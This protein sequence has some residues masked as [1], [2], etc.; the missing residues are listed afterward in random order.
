M[1]RNIRT[2]IGSAVT[3]IALTLALGGITGSTFR[4]TPLTVLSQGREPQTRRLLNDGFAPVVQKAAPAVVNISSSKMVK[5]YAVP[6]LADDVLERF[7][8]PDLEEQLGAPQERRERSLGSGVIVN[9]AGYVLTNNHVVENATE[10]TVSLSDDREFKGRVVGADPGTDIAVLKIN[11]EG[12][13]T[14]PFADS[15]KV[16][17]GDLALAIGNPFGLGRSVTM[18]VVSA[19]GRGGLGIE[20]YEDFIQT[21]A[22]IN[23]GSSGG[24]LTNIRGELIGMNTAILSPDGL[25]LGIG[26]AV[27]SNMVRDVMDQLLRTGKVSRGFM[28]VLLQD[29]TPEI[30]EAMKLG[31]TKGA[32]VGDVAPDT[33]AS[34]AGI[35]PGDVIVAADGKRITDRREL[36]LWIA[37]KVPGDRLSLKI[38]RDGLMRDVAVT[39]SEKP[40]EEKVE[41]E[42]AASAPAEDTTSRLGIVVS[43]LTPQIRQTLSIPATVKG[44][45]VAELEEGGAAAEAGMLPGDVIQ[46]LNRKPLSTAEEFEDAIATAGPDVLLLRVSR[47]GLRQFV[48]IK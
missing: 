32:L 15:S 17:V 29:I 20:D 8:G 23:P 2:S 6:G 42:E 9:A 43:D 5:T 28:G 22:S 46:E 12:L 21:D 4:T 3:I 48:A 34:L 38:Q 13:P 11:A 39:L 18:G 16:E 30:A 10:V 19:T 27:P 31:K 33:P 37:S 36:Q 44:V 41:S 35:Q 26:F 47:D 45:I 40:R 24:A 25:S 1:R 14:I 7:F